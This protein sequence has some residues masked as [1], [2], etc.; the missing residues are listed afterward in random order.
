M[1][2]ELLLVERPSVV[3]FTGILDPLIILGIVRFRF[4]KAS[5]ACFSVDSNNKGGDDP[6]ETAHEWMGLYT[7]DRWWV[8]EERV[9]R[10][11]ELWHVNRRSASDSWYFKHYI[12][13]HNHAGSSD[14]SVRFH[15]RLFCWIIDPLRVSSSKRPKTHY[16][17]PFYTRYICMHGVDENFNHLIWVERTR[18]KKK[19]S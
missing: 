17:W 9:W 15:V 3:E 10:Q 16:G 5:E 13:T 2:K 18:K 12:C 1:I 14:G 6:N 19:S 8:T 4:K 7:L 11:K